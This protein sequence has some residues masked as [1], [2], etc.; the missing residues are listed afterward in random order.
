MGASLERIARLGWPI[1]AGALVGL[2]AGAVWTLAQPARHRAEAQVFVRGAAVSRVVP[3]VKALAESSLLEQNVGQTLHLSHPPDVT[4]E[5]EGGG[6]LTLGV[7]AGSRERARQIDAQAVIVLI[8]LVSERFRATRVV[9]TQVDPAHATAQ[10]SPTPGRNLLIAGLSGLVAGLAAAAVLARRRTLPMVAAPGDP[11]LE[12]RMKQRI[13]AVTKRER[14]LARRAGELAKREKELERREEQLAAAAARPSPSERA[15]P[16][17]PAQPAP[18]P[19]PTPAPTNDVPR[20]SRWKLDELERRVRA[21]GEAQPERL[22]EWNTYL[23]FLRNH[24]DIDGNLP[25]QFDA[26]IG[27][28]FAD[29]IR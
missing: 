10:T 2:A 16:I 14:A 1:L 6:V 18:E 5:D 11:A 15:I 20:P 26:L 29:L 22:E 25:S 28:V 13:D 3:A 27:D 23:F 21:R 12:R 8:N 4:A 9:V 19:A 17:A 7:E 24:A